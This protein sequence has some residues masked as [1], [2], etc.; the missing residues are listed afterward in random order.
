MVAQGRGGAII[1]MSSVV[2]A[3]GAA[4]SVPRQ[5]AQRAE[6]GA[7]QALPGPLQAPANPARNYSRP[8]SHPRRTG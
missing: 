7:W 2:R 1:T 6:D 8:R 4:G 5:A 3:R